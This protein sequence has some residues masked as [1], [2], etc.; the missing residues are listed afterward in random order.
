MANWWK[1]RIKD[2]C[3][4]KVVFGHFLAIFWPFFGHF[5]AQPLSKVVFLVQYVL[6]VKFKKLKCFLF[7][8]VALLFPI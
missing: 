2:R 8:N 6:S 7:N 5:L 1:K 4:S 3:A